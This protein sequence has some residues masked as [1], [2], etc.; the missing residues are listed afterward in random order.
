MES[1]VLCSSLAKQIL[2]S[3]TDSNLANPNLY[4]NK[5][6]ERDRKRG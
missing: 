1:V 3:M 6:K 4:S 2:K 5:D